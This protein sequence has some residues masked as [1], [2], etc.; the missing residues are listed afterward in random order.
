MLNDL[1][2]L[3][4]TDEKGNVVAKALE[5]GSETFAEEIVR[6]WNKGRS[7]SK[8]TGLWKVSRI[9]KAGTYESHI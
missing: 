3:V 9:K 2:E 8:K 5:L 6:Y 4:L 7:L 1:W